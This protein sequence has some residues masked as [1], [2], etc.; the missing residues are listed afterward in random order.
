M[1]TRTNRAQETMESPARNY[2]AVTPHD[3]TK[4][5]FETRGLFIGVGGDVAVLGFGDSTAVVF[6]NVASGTMMPLRAVRVD[7]TN[8]TATDIVGVY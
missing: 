7:S 6:K 3:T 4:F 8:T 5:T 1:S 2:F